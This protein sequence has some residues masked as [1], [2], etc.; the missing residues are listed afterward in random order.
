MHYEKK[1]FKFIN[2]TN[3]ENTYFHLYNMYAG[4]FMN[5]ATYCFWSKLTF[6]SVISLSFLLDGETAVIVPGAN[7]PYFGWYTLTLVPHYTKK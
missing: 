6:T 1:N 3:N 2:F 5:Q 4:K 7:I